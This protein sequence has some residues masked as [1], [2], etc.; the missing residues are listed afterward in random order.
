MIFVQAGY[1]RGFPKLP[2]LA[3]R[4]MWWAV[5]NLIRRRAAVKFEF[6][7]KFGEKTAQEWAEHYGQKSIADEI[8]FYVSCSNS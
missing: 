7:E 8:N 6:V 2:E 5:K 3:C 1:E 4:R